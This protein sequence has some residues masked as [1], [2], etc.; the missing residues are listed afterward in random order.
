MEKSAKIWM[1]GK[2]VNWDDAKIHILSH[3]IH[4]GSS[5]FEGLRCYHTMKGPAIFRLNE[6]T[7]RL[8]NSCKIYR[9]KMPYSPE[10]INKAIIDLIKVNELKDCYIR[11]VVY[12]GYK[13]LGVDPTNCPVDVAI[14]VWRWGKYLGEGAIEKGVP[15]RISS[16]SRMAP[17]TFPPMAKSGGNYMNSQLIKLEALLDGYVEGIALDV[18][19]YVS[20]G[21]GENLFVVMNGSLLTPPLGASI[22]P[23]ITRDSVI[24]LADEM[25]LKVIEQLIPR[26]MLYI[27][28]E[29]FFTGSAAE[30]TPISSVDKIPVGSGTRGPITRELQERFFAIVSGNVE[31]K[32][33][34]L[35]SV[36]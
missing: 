21:S 27:A 31:D 33:G 32:Y 28:D 25:G 10:E 15:V 30:I 36:S 4:Y 7:K 8:F 11:P 23:G 5:L 2:L 20:E 22:L 6:H 9:M 16:W 19:G 13:N 26:E 24:T 18:S 1:N 3:V 35:T 14:A 12:R 17:N 34:W 29:L